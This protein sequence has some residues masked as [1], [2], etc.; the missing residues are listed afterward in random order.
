MTNFLKKNAITLVATAV[1]VGAVFAAIAYNGQ[2][3][4]ESAQVDKTTFDQ[5][6]EQAQQPLPKV[7]VQLT[8]AGG[9]RAQVVGYGE[10]K[11]RFEL[12]YAAEVSGRVE[13]LSNAFETGRTVQKDELL[14][15]LDATQ[16]EQALTA[17]EYELTIARQALLEEQRQG[18]QARSEWQ[19]SGLEGTP[20]SPLVLREPQLAAAKAKLK[21]AEKMR[22]K[23]RNDLEKTEIR[24]PF[25][26]VIVSRDIQPGSYLNAG[27]LIATL[28]SIDRIEIEIPLSEK[29]WENLPKPAS[30]TEWSATITDSTGVNHWAARIERSHHYVSGETR[31]R[32]IVL[33]IDQPL[34]Q[35]EPLYP[36]T[37][38]QATIEGAEVDN[39]WQLP[40]SALSQQGEIWTVNPNG[41]L[42]KAAAKKV[43]E[44]QGQIYVEPTQAQHD[45][46]VVMRPLSSYKEGMKVEPELSGSSTMVT[47]RINLA[48]EES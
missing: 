24:A 30:N 34:E 11:P 28:Y 37:F 22:Q 13:W 38:V 31:Q 19:R 4:A 7:G 9:Y 39:L 18:E 36:G 3:I 16:Y 23:A 6:G 40:A 14:A 5:G 41:L 1:A 43:F 10:T 29:Q 42:A 27:T 47:T 45:A 48:S 46:L 2:Q 35:A 12:T 26:G 17:A 15:K 33:A 21:N 44:R 25:D 8:Q 32:S 20:G